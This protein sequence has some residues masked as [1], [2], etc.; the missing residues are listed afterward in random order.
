MARSKIYLLERNGTTIASELSIAAIRL[1]LVKQLT[2]AD[3]KRIPK[4]NGIVYHVTVKG[5]YEFR[6]DLPAIF[7]IQIFKPTPHRNAK[8]QIS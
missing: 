8:N 5:G 1:Q 2:P 7:K 6:S 3:A 4:Y